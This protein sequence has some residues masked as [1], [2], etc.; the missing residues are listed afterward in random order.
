M[1]K[2]TLGGGRTLRPRNTH[3][4]AAPSRATTAA[5]HAIHARLR[6]LGGAGAIADASD[7]TDGG[8]AVSHASASF[9]SFALC[10][11]SSG[12]FARHFVTTRSSAA[13]AVGCNDDTV[14]G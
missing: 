11:R 9:R 8:S 14:G 7:A 6:F 12:S 13:G 3:P 2:A 5:A 4:L 10:Q 1:S